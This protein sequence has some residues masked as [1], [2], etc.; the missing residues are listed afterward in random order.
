[1][2]V[3]LNGEYLDRSRALISVDD[4]GFLFGDGVYEVTRACNGRLFEWERH[5]RRLR[6]GLTGLS[7]MLPPG[8]D[9]AALNAISERLLRD[10]GL[11]AGHATVYLQ[12][13]RG[14]A[15]RKHQ[16]PPP[17]TAPTIFLSAARLTVPDDVR[18]A[19]AR[20]VTTPDLRWSRCDLKTVNLLPNV[21]AKQQAVAAGA[22]EAVMVRD[23][24]VTEGASSNVFAVIGGE[25]RTHPLTPRILAGIT[26]EVVLELA[27]ELGFRVVEQPVTAADFVRASEAFVTATTA[28]VMPVTQIDGRPVGDGRPGRMT[29]QL[30][31]AFRER[32]ERVTADA[33]V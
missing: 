33:A 7:L 16:F 4:R 3:Y 31:A 25:L 24:I 2:T 10:N 8:I 23:G 17:G 19:G 5:V 15:A 28:D 22:F 12:I 21:L 11:E 14:V 30:A 29:R 26:R 9:G 32:L 18:E 27:P 20:T 6:H 13:T 1:M